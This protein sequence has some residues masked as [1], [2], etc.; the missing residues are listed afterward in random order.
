MGKEGKKC[1]GD[2]EERQR[3]RGGAREKRRKSKERE[4]EGKEE[5]GREEKKGKRTFRV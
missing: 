1:A 2:R 5:K 4:G 3:D